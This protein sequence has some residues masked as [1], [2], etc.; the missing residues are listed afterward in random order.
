MKNYINPIYLFAFFFSLIIITGCEKK[1]EEPD[2]TALLTS[3]LWNFSELT[4][5]S[6]DPNVQLAV[7]LV[8]AFLTNATMTFAPGGTYTITMLG[9]PDT[10][11]W[12]FNASETTITLNKGT[13]DESIQEIIKLTS[14]VLETKEIMQDEELGEFDITYHWIK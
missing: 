13:D 14:S 9:Q 6:T 5:T 4:T 7:N 3:H 1:E 12:E 11:S 8:A 2:K 10:G